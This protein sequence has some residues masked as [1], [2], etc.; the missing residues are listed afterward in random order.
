MDYHLPM[1]MSNPVRPQPLPPRT[2]GFN[3]PLGIRPPSPLSVDLSSKRKAHVLD[4][5]YFDRDSFASF[6]RMDDGDR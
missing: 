6:A 2:L 1:G 5:D 3:D 4:Y